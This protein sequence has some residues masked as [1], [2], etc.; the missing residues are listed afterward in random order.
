MTLCYGSSCANNGKG[1]LNTPDL[2]LRLDTLGGGDW[3]KVQGLASTA[4]NLT[5]TALRDVAK[6]SADLKKANADE[7]AA[8]ASV[9]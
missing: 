8:Q 5:D 2:T 6:G 3:Q 1:A 7:A 9:R 4:R